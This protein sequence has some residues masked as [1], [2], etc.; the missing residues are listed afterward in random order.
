L[1]PAE[2]P[3]EAADQRADDEPAD[4][5]EVLVVSEDNIIQVASESWD[6]K[7]SRRRC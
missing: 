5:D 1:E 6:W 4:D 2:A 7:P 3:D